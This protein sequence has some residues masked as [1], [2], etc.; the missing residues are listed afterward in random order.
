MIKKEWR[1]KNTVGP[2]HVVIKEFTVGDIVCGPQHQV[3]YYEDLPPEV[4]EAVDEDIINKK[5]S[6]KSAI[7]KELMYR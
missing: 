1:I 3:F 6:R 4:H 5:S 2:E 7:E